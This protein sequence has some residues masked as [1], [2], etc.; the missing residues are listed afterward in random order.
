VSLFYSILFYS[1]L[2]YSI[3]ILFYSILVYSILVYSILFYSILFYSI[4][5]YSILF[6]SVLFYST[7]AEYAYQKGKRIIPLKMEQNYS[8][9]GWLGIILGTKLYY[10]FRYLFY[11]I[12][13]YL[14]TVHTSFQIVLKS[15]KNNCYNYMELF[16]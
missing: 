16:L 2:F 8:A 7:E 9:D 13:L 14:T 4:L 10:E 11:V 15:N 3:L 1:I 5:F 12:K 6:Y